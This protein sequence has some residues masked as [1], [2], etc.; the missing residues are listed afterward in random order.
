MKEIKILK[1]VDGYVTIAKD[2]VTGFDTKGEAIGYI[3]N[4]LD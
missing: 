3:I 1:D 4:N 2:V